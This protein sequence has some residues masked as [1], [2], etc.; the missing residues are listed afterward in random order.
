[1]ISCS[2]KEL[3]QLSNGQIPVLT[4]WTFLGVPVWHTV[5]YIF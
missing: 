5:H 3:P 4:S 2:V 1:M